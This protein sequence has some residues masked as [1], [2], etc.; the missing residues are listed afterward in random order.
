[1]NKKQKRYLIFKRLIDVVVS[2]LTIPL[3][4]SFFW[5]WI[6]IINLFVTKG[7]P[8]FA[9]KRL[10]KNKKVFRI[11]KFRTMKCNA[12]SYL[13]PSD[14]DGLTQYNMETK[15]GHFLRKSQLDETLQLFN[16]LIG[17]MSF[18]GP[19]PGAAKNEDKL[20]VEREKLSKDIYSLRPGLTGLAQIELNENKHNPPLKAQED[21]EYLKSVSLALDVR[22]FLKT[23]GKFFR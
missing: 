4:L 17:Q 2:I 11:L 1:M 10:G 20:V 16:I 23:L 18:V 19:R 5:W 15:F 6:F 22:I 14:M 13:P 8:F 12:D 7:H 3:C 21:Y 9:Q